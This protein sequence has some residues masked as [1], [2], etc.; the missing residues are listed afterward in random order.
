MLSM[1]YHVA[2][3][4]MVVG[5]LLVGTGVAAVLYWLLGKPGVKAACEEPTSP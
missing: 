5:V 4:A 1:F 3:A 2:M